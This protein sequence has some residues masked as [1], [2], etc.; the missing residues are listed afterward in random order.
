MAHTARR[1][2]THDPDVYPNPEVFDPTR[3]L[4]LTDRSRKDYGAKDGPLDPRLYTFGYGRRICSGMH[5]GQSS[6][7][8]M[9]ASVL[10]TFT[11]RK[12]IVGGKEI[13]PEHGFMAETVR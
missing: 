4:Y 1:T 10:A 2:T 13:T 6:V 11:I 8:I 7:F 3:F 12:K 9:I 5:L